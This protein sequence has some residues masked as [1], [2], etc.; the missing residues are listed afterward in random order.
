MAA[1]CCEFS[2]RSECYLGFDVEVGPV[3]TLGSSCVARGCGNCNAMTLMAEGL[4]VLGNTAFGVRIENAPSNSVGA[5]ALSPGPCSG[6]SFL[7]G[8]FYAGASPAVVLPLGT[9]RGGSSCS[10]STSLALPIPYDEDFCGA[11]VCMQA[12]LLCPS[13]DLS[14]TEGLYA[15]IEG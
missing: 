10:G 14:L 12:V 1:A 11:G 9:L 4:P 6:F 5:L 8:T 13:G 2:S 3:G 7:C 15:V